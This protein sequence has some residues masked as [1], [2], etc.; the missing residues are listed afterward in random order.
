MLLTKS[1]LRTAP[2]Q[3]HPSPARQRE[4]RSYIQ[5]KPPRRIRSNSNPGPTHTSHPHTPGAAGP[6]RSKHCR[7]TTSSPR[8]QRESSSFPE[9]A[10]ERR[11]GPAA[12]RHPRPAQESV[13]TAPSS[14]P[15][16]T[17]RAQRDQTGASIEGDHPNPSRTARKLP[18][19]RACLRAQDRSRCARHPR[20]AQESVLTAPS[21][22]PTCT[23]RAQRDRTGASI[24]GEPPHPLAHSAKA[25]PS[26][27]LPASAGT[28]P[29]RPTPKT[30]PRRAAP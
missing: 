27:S 23:P 25:P 15:T 28:V 8:A 12:S 20:P 3:T 16:R 10:C 2:N 6:D 13:L 9:P 1:A 30:H 26:P 24:A 17:P 11:H 29:L 5:P 22:Q 14:Q 7:R 19:P 4:T 21:S 18:L